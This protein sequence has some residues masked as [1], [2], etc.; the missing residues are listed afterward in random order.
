[1]HASEAAR[2]RRQSAMTASTEAKVTTQRYEV[3]DSLVT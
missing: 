1:M 2:L 3:V